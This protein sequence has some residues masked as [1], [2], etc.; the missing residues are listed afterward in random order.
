MTYYHVSRVCTESKIGNVC[1]EVY[2]KLGNA[3]ITASPVDLKPFVDKHVQIS[4]EFVK[5][6]GLL[7]GRDKKLC[8]KQTCDISPGPGQWVSSPI[9]ITAIKINP[10]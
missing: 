9:T 4:G 6:Q 5:T 1:K 2:E 8:I 10:K 7:E 3:A